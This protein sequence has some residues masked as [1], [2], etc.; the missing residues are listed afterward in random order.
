[1]KN[2]VNTIKARGGECPAANRREELE[3]ALNDWRTALQVFDSA[4]DAVS[5]QLAAIKLDSAGRRFGC[6]AEGYRE[7][8]G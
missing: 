1:M 4:E 6:L 5:M 2:S 3:A 7:E 8:M